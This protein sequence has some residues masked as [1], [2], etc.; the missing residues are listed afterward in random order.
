MLPFDHELL[1]GLRRDARFG[2]VLTMA[3]GGV[4]AEADPDVV[5]LLLPT[6]DAEVLRALQSLRYARLLQG[7]RDKPA[8]DLPT[9]ARNIAGLS[10]WFMHQSLREVE[11]NP[12]AIQGEN[13]WALDALIAPTKD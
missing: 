5:N 8:A 7:F 9:A 3:R 11:I 12:L 2:P 13:T 6:N 10:T 1:V 4:E